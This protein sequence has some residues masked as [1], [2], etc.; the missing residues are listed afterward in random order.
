MKK[1]R[2]EQRYVDK[3]IY[4]GGRAAMNTLIKENLKYP[5]K[6]IKNKIEGKVHLR[7]EIDYKGN[8]VRTSVISS[9]GYG[10]DEE[11]ERL[12]KLLKFEIPKLPRKM[13]LKFNKTIRITF[14]LPKP[15]PKSK[16]KITG[17]VN[18]TKGQKI[19]A[20]GGSKVTYRIT[21]TTTTT[22]QPSK[23]PTYTYT[24]TVS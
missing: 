14:K 23:K 6:A 16:K 13:R 15:K 20:P 11:A 2:K 24:V 10:C 8:V 4:R 7:Y 12:V 17:N 3:P 18:L 22:T 9:L 5:P 1:K 19:V 21:P